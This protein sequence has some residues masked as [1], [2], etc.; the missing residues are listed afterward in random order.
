MQATVDST[1][2]VVGM[3]DETVNFNIGSSC[4][5]TATL[6]TELPTGTIVT[7]YDPVLVPLPTFTLEPAICMPAFAKS[8]T[9]PMAAVPADVPYSLNGAEN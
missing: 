6:P 4:L 2:T 9:D 3:I 1:D 8:L 7:Y 5:V